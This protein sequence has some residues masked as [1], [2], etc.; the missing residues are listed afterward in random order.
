MFTK[1]N[2]KAEAFTLIELL[3]VITI[4]VIL[5][6]IGFGLA[7]VV[8]GTSK[9]ELTKATLRNAKLIETEL[10]NLTG[11]RFEG[12]TSPFMSTIAKTPKLRPYLN[13]FP[14]Y[15]L[16]ENEDY[17]VGQGRNYRLFDAWGTRIYY[18][19]DGKS[20]N[21]NWR[22]GVYGRL[23][24]DHQYYFASSGPDGLFGDAKVR[25]SDSREFYQASDNLYSF[26]VE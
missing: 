25:D 16:K 15:V 7:G 3:I 19:D 4:I 23:P 24:R 9:I 8:Q 1:S 22:G 11:Q 5:V 14:E 2:P 17:D 18:Y 10:Y 12:T 13:Q 26:T 21:G 20:S 6:S